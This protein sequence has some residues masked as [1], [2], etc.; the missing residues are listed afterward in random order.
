M[1]VNIC[2]ILVAAFSAGFPTISHAQTP[3]GAGK[4][5]GKKHVIRSPLDL[6][7]VIFENIHLKPAQTKETE[8]LM[9]NLRTELQKENGLGLAPED[10]QE[11]RRKIRAIRMEYQNGLKKTLTADQLKKYIAL[12]QQ[13]A[14][15]LRNRRKPGMHF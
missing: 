9:Q 6:E 15:Q 8:R 7:R 1:K 3:S 12:H 4:H 10:P 13:V 5:P 11:K 14:A 2:W